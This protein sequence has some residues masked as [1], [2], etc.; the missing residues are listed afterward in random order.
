MDALTLAAQLDLSHM[1]NVIAGTCGEGNNVRVWLR[2]GH[3]I[4][5]ARSQSAVLC[6]M[7][8]RFTEPF[9]PDWTEEPEFEFIKK[10]PNAHRLPMGDPSHTCNHLFG[11]DVHGAIA[12][13]SRL[14][15][16][17]RAQPLKTR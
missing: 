1:N 6:I 12:V 14:Y 5:I 9:D 3:G 8:V 17:D 11:T 15:E 13:L 7:P 16:L 2:N 4:A 10:S